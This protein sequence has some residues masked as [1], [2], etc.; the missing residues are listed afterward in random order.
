MSKFTINKR[1]LASAMAAVLVPGLASAAVVTVG[2]GT[3]HAFEVTN[4]TVVTAAVNTTFSYDLQAG[5][6]LIGRTGGNI[7]VRVTLTGAD[8]TGTVPSVTATQGALVGAPIVSGNVLSFVMAPPTAPGFTA[9]ALFTITAPT[10]ATTAATALTTQGG[11]VVA[12]VD[13]RDTGTGSSLQ[14][15]VNGT[16]LTSTQASATS[17]A[18]ATSTTASVASGKK[19][20]ITGIG[21]GFVDANNITLGVVTA[22]ANTGGINPVMAAG[23]GIGDNIA[24]TSL[25]FQFDAIGTPSIA[26]SLRDRLGVQVNFVDTTGFSQVYLSSTAC[27]TGTTTVVNAAAAETVLTPTGN[28]YAGEIDLTSATSQVF[29]ICGRVNGTGVIKNQAVTA[30]ARINYINAR[31]TLF[32]TAT[33]V[34]NIGYDGTS[35]DVDWFNPSNNVQQLSML[36]ITNP[37][38]TNGLVTITGR[39]DDGAATSGTATFTLLAGVSRLLSSQALASGA[40]LSTPLGTCGVAGKLRLNVTGEFANM[41]VQNFV[42]SALSSGEITTN[43]NNEK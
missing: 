34:S 43:V 26:P 15:A 12:A 17:L 42:K 16:V 31:D 36:R 19:S 38:T 27:A 41:K 14:T 21:S 20:F 8:Y 9:S 5:D 37:S 23:S 11:N 1:V 10:L 7:S 22:T 3:K 32:N 24:G 28:T 30:S 35:V 29:N 2:T 39:C 13:V 33:T 18:A 40:G 4:Q 6:I 25:N